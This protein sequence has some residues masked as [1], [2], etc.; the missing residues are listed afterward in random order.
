MLHHPP[1][2]GKGTVMK[3]RAYLCIIV[4]V[5]LCVSMLQGCGPSD[6]ALANAALLDRQTAYLDTMR[7]GGAFIKNPEIRTAIVE[8]TEKFIKYRLHD[9]RPYYPYYRFVTTAQG[10]ILSTWSGN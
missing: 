10:R 3:K 1:R 8:Q 4:G 2:M 9:P 6:R 7:V 5:L